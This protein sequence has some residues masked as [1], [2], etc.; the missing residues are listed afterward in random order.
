MG[1]QASVIPPV[2]LIYQGGLL[3]H[4]IHPTTTDTKVNRII[5]LRICKKGQVNSKKSLASCKIVIVKVAIDKVP[6][7]LIA[8]LK[9]PNVTEKWNGISVIVTDDLASYKLLPRNSITWTSDLPVSCVSL[10]RVDSLGSVIHGFQSVTMG[11]GWKLATYRDLA[12]RSQQ[13]FVWVVEAA[14]QGGVPSLIEHVL[15][16]NCVI[17]YC[18]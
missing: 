17:C 16:W 8:I 13:T 18:G 6:A 5:W 12:F 4:I 15:L 2:G 14:C 3:F 7:M 9:L 10:G 11:F 1:G